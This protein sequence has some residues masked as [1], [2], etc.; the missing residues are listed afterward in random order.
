MLCNFM[1]YLIR[2]ILSSSLAH[3]HCGCHRSNGQTWKGGS[4]E[5]QSFIMHLQ[6]Q[7]VPVSPRTN[8]KS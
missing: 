2:I 6:R 7:G 5:Y 4:H 3:P 1:S 8:V